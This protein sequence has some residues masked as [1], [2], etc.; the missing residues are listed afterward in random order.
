[1][2]AT[3]EM[4]I[5]P[6]RS[7]PRNQAS[8][9]VATGA[10]ATNSGV[11]VVSRRKRESGTAA[12]GRRGATSEGLHD[13]GN[14]CRLIPKANCQQAN[15]RRREQFWTQPA[16]LRRRIATPTSGKQATRTNA[17]LPGSGTFV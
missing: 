14:G 15:E 5:L 9:P 8:S 6:R 1:M 16:Y 13:D 12:I 7:S 2:A 11:R 17:T 4:P 10:I 3:R